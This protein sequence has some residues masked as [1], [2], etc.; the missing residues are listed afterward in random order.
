MQYNNYRSVREGGAFSPLPTRLAAGRARRWRIQCLSRHTSSRNEARA[1]GGA[2]IM[3]E[4]IP[5]SLFKRKVADDPSVC[6]RRQ[7]QGPYR[8]CPSQPVA[9]Y[10][11]RAPLVSLK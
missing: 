5:R 2:S 11:G 6:W 3:I 1:I 7:P 8:R 10:M 4:R 9:T